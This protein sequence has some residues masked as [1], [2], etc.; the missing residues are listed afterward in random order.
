MVSA[1]GTGSGPGS[2][3]GVAGEPRGGR[4]DPSSGRPGPVRPAR[5]EVGVVAGLGEREH[6]RH[7]GVRPVEHGRPLVARAGGEGR[8]EGLALRRPG[9]L[10]VLLP[11]RLDAEHRH[12]LG[13]ELRLE[14]TDG[15]E[16]CRRHTR[17]RR[18]RAHRRRAGSPPARRATRL[19]RASSAPS[20]AGAPRPRP[21][22]RRRPARAPWC[23]ATRARRARRRRGTSPRPRSR[24]GPAP[25]RSAAP[26]APARGACR[27][28]RR[29]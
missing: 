17:T 15:D 7:A 20:S 19:P 29:R 8:R 21:S 9:P 4:R 14:R 12:E 27:R 13:P 16:Q 6:R 10:V 3:C 18:R 1:P 24:R 23:P 11:D 25:A 22:P 5:R 2:R 28:A 26:A